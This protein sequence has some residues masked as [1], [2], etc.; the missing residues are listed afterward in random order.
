MWHYK[1]GF[2]E[3]EDIEK[4]PNSKFPYK[5]IVFGG[6]HS[7]LVAKILRPRGFAKAAWKEDDPIDD[8][9]FIWRPVNF[10]PKVGFFGERYK[11]FRCSFI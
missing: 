2:Q 1:P 3:F 5:Y 7:D 6:N 9:D 4:D 8:I 11:T 10:S